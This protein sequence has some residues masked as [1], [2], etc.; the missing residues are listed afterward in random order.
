MEV[1]NK[2]SEIVNKL[3]PIYK[4][5]RT[6]DNGFEIIR[7]EIITKKYRDENILYTPLFFLGKRNHL[8]LQNKGCKMN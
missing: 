7:L 4:K 3:N 1:V 8:K 5:T 6:Y 2:F